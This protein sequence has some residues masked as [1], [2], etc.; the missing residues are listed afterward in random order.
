MRSGTTWTQQEK[1][2]ASDGAADDYF[3]DSVAISGD[4]VVVGAGRTTSAPT[5]PGSAYVF[6]RS[7]TVWT[8]QAEADRRRRLPPAT[9]SATRSRSR[10]DTVVVGAPYDDVGANADQGSAYVFVRS[11]AAWSQQQKL[12]ASDGAAGDYFGYSV[13]ISGD[14]VV[15]GAP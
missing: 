6:V 11:G 13:A 8:Q 7:G 9:T 10:G 2:T 4:T 14:T 5:E 3:G 1:L 15:V 12:T